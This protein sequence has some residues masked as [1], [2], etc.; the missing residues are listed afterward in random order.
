MDDDEKEGS[1]PLPTIG[2]AV[3]KAANSGPVKALLTPAAKAFGD[4]LGWRINDITEGWK[5]QRE[6]NLEA[7]AAKVQEKDGAPVLREPTEKQLILISEWIERAQEVDPDDP[8]IAALWQ[9]LLGAIYKKQASANEWL[10][11]I[12]QLNEADARFLMRISRAFEAENSREKVQANK[13]ASLG[14]LQGFDLSRAGQ[15]LSG[16]ALV[17][18]ASVLFVIVFSVNAPSR[19]LIGSGLEAEAFKALIMGSGVTLAVVGLALMVRS[20]LRELNR[21]SVTDLGR[22]IQQS[23]LRYLDKKAGLEIAIDEKKSKRGRRKVAETA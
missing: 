23:A 3:A 5:K 17:Y 9:S 14:L 21:Y 19:L 4:Y 6:K 13:L 22:D 20:F 1:I 18:V 7:H 8:E 11:I 16:E 2:N 15:R 12:K 10:D